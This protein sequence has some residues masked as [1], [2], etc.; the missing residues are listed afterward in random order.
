VHIPDGILSPSLCAGGFALGAAAV[1]YSLHRF[2]ERNLPQVA[3]MAS[4]FFVASSIQIPLGQASLHLLLNGLLG[5]VLGRD[6]APAIVVSL[7]LQSL[8]LQHG[9][10][11]ALGA[12]TV[13]MM[14]GSLAAHLLF[15]TGRAL[16][17]RKGKGGPGPAL[18][19]LGLAAGA[20]SV[21][22]SGLLYYLFLV[23]ADPNYRTFSFFVVSLQIPLL[24][25]EPIVTASAVSFLA[26]VKP[27][28]IDGGRG[29]P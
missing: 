20:A 21:V 7:L 5:V 22:V 8:L 12:N 13:T 24:L 4:L 3:V 11:T 2:H 18:T 16:L 15:R 6:A 10:L 23:L 9:G 19:A 14:G 27:E 29:K 28:L 17:S 25:F 1:G 26:R